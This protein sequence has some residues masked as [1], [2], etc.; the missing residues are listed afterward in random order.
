MNDIL[1][2]IEDL[3]MLEVLD[4][5]SRTGHLDH[6]ITKYKTRFEDIERDMERQG[7]FEFFHG[8]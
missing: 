3:E 8:S 2:M 7:E 6:L 1:E 5:N 4:E